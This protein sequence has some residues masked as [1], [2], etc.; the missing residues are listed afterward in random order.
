[1][2]FHEFSRIGTRPLDLKGL[3]LITSSRG[4]ALCKNQKLNELLVTR[5]V[6][7]NFSVWRTHTRT[8][9]IISHALAHAPRF[10]DDR[11]RTCTFFYMIYFMAPSLKA[12]SF[13][14]RNMHY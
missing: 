9:I 7:R 13:S 12:Q 3:P 14:Y 11:T 8:L 2:M 5:W 6:V 1:M 10:F 4:R